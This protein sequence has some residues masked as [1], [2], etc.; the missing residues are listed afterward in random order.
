MSKTIPLLSLLTLTAVAGCGSGTDAAR[1][2]SAT[3]EQ[4]PSTQAALAIGREWGFARAISS[5]ERFQTQCER[6]RSSAGLCED[7]FLACAGAAESAFGP[8]LTASLV[9][10]PGSPGGGIVPPEEIVTALEKKKDDEP[11]MDYAMCM[12]WCWSSHTYCK[13]HQA[14]EIDCDHHLGVC[15]EACE[16]EFDPQFGG[17]DRFLGLD[18]LP[19]LEFQ[20]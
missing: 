18:D 3:G 8:L 15:I 2:S 9:T 6:N 11:E 17:V 4:S 10:D 20:R 5:C 1:D 12:N 13:D 7:Q 16:S 19:V 14:D